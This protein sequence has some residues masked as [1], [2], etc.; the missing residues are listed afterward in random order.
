MFLRPSLLVIGA[1]GSIGTLA[2]MTCSPPIPLAA[3]TEEYIS[4]ECFSEPELYFI[5]PAGACFL[6]HLPNFIKYTTK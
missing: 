2:A 4:P 6:F 5:Y 3:V 1:P